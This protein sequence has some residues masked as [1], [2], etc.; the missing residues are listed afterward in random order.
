MRGPVQQLFHQFQPSVALDLSGN[1]ESYQVFTAPVNWRFRSGDRVEINVN[2]TGERL[3]EPF[4]VARGAVVP[5]GSY[6]W[7]RYRLEAGTAQKRRLYTQV[8]WWFGGF[9]DG[10]LDQLQWTGAWNPTPLLT[11]EFTGERNLG[12]LPSGRFTQTLVGTRLR[13]NMSSDLSVSSYAQYDTDSESVG[14]NTRLRWTF[15]PVADV[16]VVYNHNV[17]SLLDRWQLDSNQLLVKLQ[18]AWRT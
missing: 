11:I 8:T 1:W 18:Y 5:P 15:T 4:E 17:R 7:R 6:H 12:R 3:V 9:Y 13:V 14:V 2:P 16:F 10:D